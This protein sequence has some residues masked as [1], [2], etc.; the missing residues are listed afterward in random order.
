MSALAAAR[1][2]V[3]GRG[4]GLPPVL[5]GQIVSGAPRGAP[6]VEV[7]LASSGGGGG[8]SS[9]NTGSGGELGRS[10]APGLSAAAATPGKFPHP[11]PHSV[12]LVAPPSPATPPAVGVAL[13]RRARRAVRAI[14]VSVRGRCVTRRYLSS[15]FVREHTIGKGSFGTVQLAK[16]RWGRRVAR[17]HV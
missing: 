8:S 12:A 11:P 15:E 4:G 10:V 6:A 9:S 14:R 2:P 7:A 17:H 1:A 5:P 13:H 16:L 3:G